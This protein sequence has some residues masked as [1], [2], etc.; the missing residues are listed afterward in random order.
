MN[1]NQRPT[2]TQLRRLVAAANDS[3]GQHV[4]W[5]GTDGAVNLT[6][7]RAGHAVDLWVERMA[8]QIRHRVATFQAGE[9]YVG[10]AAST[11]TMSFA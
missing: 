10:A 6:T 5:I 2:I 8:G 11:G 3:A 4:M 9:R 1:M 7:L